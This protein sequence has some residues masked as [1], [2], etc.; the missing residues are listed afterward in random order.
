MR[1]RA[2]FVITGMMVL[3]TGCRPQ[4]EPPRQPV[5]DPNE[6]V[7]SR[8]SDFDAQRLELLFLK[9]EERQGLCGISEKPPRGVAHAGNRVHWIVWNGCKQEVRL[10]VRNFSVDG[11]VEDPFRSGPPDDSIPPGRLGTIRRHLRAGPPDQ[12]KSGPYLYEYDI[13]FVGGA[14]L[15]P[16][17]VI[18][19][20]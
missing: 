13:G 14:D 9:L 7:G 11:E 5:T 16:E 8:D 20:P 1:R 4:T 17:L 18:I 12:K 3:L 19:W 10:E 6:F 2:A 15:D